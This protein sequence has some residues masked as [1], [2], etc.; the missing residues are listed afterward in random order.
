MNAVIGVGAPWYT[1]GTHAWNGT[2]PILNNSAAATMTVPTSTRPPL[3]DPVSIAEA[4][5]VRLRVPA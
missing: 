3:S 5:P 1:S 2:A 4:M